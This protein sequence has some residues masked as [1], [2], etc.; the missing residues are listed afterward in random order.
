MISRFYI[1]PQFPERLN[2]VYKPYCFSKLTL[3]HG[4]VKIYFIPM[5]TLKRNTPT[6]HRAFSEKVHIGKI[7]N[8]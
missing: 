5:I 3:D 4:G 6:K 2:L 8:C 7:R 1:I